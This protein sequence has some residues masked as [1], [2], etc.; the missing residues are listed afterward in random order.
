MPGQA[1]PLRPPLTTILLVDANPSLRTLVRRM[2]Q[3][4][5]YL[6]LEVANPDDLLRLPGA[7]RIHFDAL[8]AELSLPRMSGPQFADR[9]A[10]LGR[11]VPALYYTADPRY[12]GR[13]LGA[14]EALILM[15]FG[16]TDF[17]A[18]LRTLLS[19]TEA[20]RG[21]V[22]PASHILKL[23]ENAEDLAK[24]VAPFLV[25]GLKAGERVTVVAR[26]EHWEAIEAAMAKGGEDP[27]AARDH[28]KVEVL[29]ARRLLENLGSARGADPREA[30]TGVVAPI[31]SGS[32]APVRI[33]AEMVDLLW[34]SGHLHSALALEEVWNRHLD[35]ARGRL[36]C[37]YHRDLVKAAEPHGV[38]QVLESHS[39][40]VLA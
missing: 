35:P 29:D 25:E 11:P 12:P 39:H 32:A 3:H 33:Y 14:Q 26:A 34:Q 15:P 37:G 9:L 40:V 5:G 4:H 22:D 1:F 16:M 7:E 2:L 38:V 30:M 24:T 36:L 17:L 21:P 27:A 6:V 31:A 19:E 23:Y 13:E 10:E 18:R 20:P 8:V 28:G